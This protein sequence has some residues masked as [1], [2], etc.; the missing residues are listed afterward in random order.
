MQQSVLKESLNPALAQQ[1][2]NM[3]MMGLEDGEEI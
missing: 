3:L 1:V 2:M